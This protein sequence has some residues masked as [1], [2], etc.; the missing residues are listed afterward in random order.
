VSIEIGYQSGKYH[1]KNDLGVFPAGD[2][3]LTHESQ[4]LASSDKQ[5]LDK[6]LPRI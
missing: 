1:G 6:L 3:R 4:V 5:M 2:D